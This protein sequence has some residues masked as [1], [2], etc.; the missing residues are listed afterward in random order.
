METRGFQEAIRTAT[1]TYPIPF[2]FAV[3]LLFA[4]LCFGGSLLAEG[5]LRWV[6]VGTALFSTVSSVGLLAYA[7]LFNTELLRSERH[8]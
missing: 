6:L 2:A 1:V 4:L 7:V 3:L 8:V 5:A